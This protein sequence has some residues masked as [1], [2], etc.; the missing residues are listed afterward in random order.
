[1]LKKEENFP[2]S[3]KIETRTQEEDENGNSGKKIKEENFDQQRQAIVLIHAFTLNPLVSL[4]FSYF[5]WAVKTSEVYKR[6]LK[7]NKENVFVIALE[8]PRK[9]FLH[10]DE[11]TRS[12]SSEIKERT[13]NF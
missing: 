4:G 7:F 5:S 1:M 13:S 12:F 8:F 9:S 11:F 6:M 3:E 10:I 2:D